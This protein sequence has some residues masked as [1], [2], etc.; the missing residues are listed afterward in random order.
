MDN[1]TKIYL[2]NLIEAVEKLDSPDWWTFGATVFVGLVAAWISYK[3]GKQQ[4]KLQQQQ[5]SLSE[6]ELNKQLYSV[7]RDIDELSDTFIMRVYSHFYSFIFVMMKRDILGEL[8]CDIEN[9]Q[10]KLYDCI[11]DIELKLNGDMEDSDSYKK[12][13][14]KMRVLVLCMKEI[15]DLKAIDTTIDNIDKQDDKA[16]QSKIISKI[17]DDYK[18][19]ITHVFD[20]FVKQQDRV[21][22]L[23][24]L[25]KIKKRIEP[26]SGK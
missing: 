12:L 13:L 10:R 5:I 9:A 18:E 23:K 7:I 15:A 2:D 26:I 25:K 17:N 8:Q 24:T 21:R 20:D 4:E 19:V 1:E 6:Y 3:F 22:K 16:L 11:L 14:E